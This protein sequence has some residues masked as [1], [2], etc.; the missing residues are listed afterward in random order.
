MP[1][2]SSSISFCGSYLGASDRQIRGRT[3]PAFTY[4]HSKDHRPDLKQLLFILT[5][6]ADSNIPVAF[7]CTN[8]NASDSRTH[9][10]TWNKLRAV[11]GRSNFLYAAD[12]KL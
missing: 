7:R 2:D 4:G 5:M 8:G 10:E 1:N 12:S 9:I 6:T 11:A 3:A